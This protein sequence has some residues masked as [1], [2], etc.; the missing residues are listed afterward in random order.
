[1]LLSQ[2][3]VGKGWSFAWYLYYESHKLAYIDLYCLLQRVGVKINNVFEMIQSLIFLII[4]YK[5]L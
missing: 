4:L 1:M 5:S 3:V 2:K